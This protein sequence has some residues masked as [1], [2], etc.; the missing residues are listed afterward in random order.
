[1]NFSIWPINHLDRRADQASD[2]RVVVAAAIQVRASLHLGQR[3]R[4]TNWRHYSFQMHQ[5][6]PATKSRPGR[7][8]AHVR[9]SGFQPF[10]LRTIKP[11]FFR[12]AVGGQSRNS[13][14]DTRRHE[15][16]PASGLPSGAS[17]CAIQNEPPQVTPS[18]LL[19]AMFS[20][21]TPRSN[22]IGNRTGISLKT[23]PRAKR[24][25]SVR[26]PSNSG[27][28]ILDAEP[29]AAILASVAILACRAIAADHDAE[30]LYEAICRGEHET[31]IVVDKCIGQA[32]TVLAVDTVATLTT[33]GAGLARITL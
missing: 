14:F 19:Y 25:V 7:P 6:L 1:M 26:S 33:I 32:D 23:S 2:L 11:I 30:T 9:L 18:P 20:L 21:K 17:F 4:E 28:Q 27:R 13:A 10:G 12:Y 29:V 31:S 15:P 22:G 16:L 24:S 8:L 3:H 5:I